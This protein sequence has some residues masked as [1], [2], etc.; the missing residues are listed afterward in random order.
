[1]ATQTL[2]WGWTPRALNGGI[3]MTGGGSQLRHLTPADG[4]CDGVEY[5]HRVS[6]RHLA[7]GHIEEL[8]K[9][10]Y[11]TCIGLILKGYSD[12][13]HNHDNSIKVSGGWKCRTTCGKQGRRMKGRSGH[14]RTRA[15]PTGK[16]SQQERDEGFL[17]QFKDGV[18]DLFKEERRPCF[19]IIINFVFCSKHL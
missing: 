8:A 13:E 4:I 12:Y 18:I 9:P 6:D 3:V 7:A 11:S 10:T 2:R 16:R 14:G 5:P 15:T 1:M 17:G 19:I